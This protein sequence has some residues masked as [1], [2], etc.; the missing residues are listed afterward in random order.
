[1]S[2]NIPV[3]TMNKVHLL[4]NWGAHNSQKNKV[5]A[6]EGKSHTHIKIHINSNE[7]ISK[8][9]PNCITPKTSTFMD[10]AEHKR[11]C[12]GLW[13]SSFQGKSV[14]SSKWGTVLGKWITIKLCSSSIVCL[15]IYC[16]PEVGIEKFQKKKGKPGMQSC[17]LTITL[18]SLEICHGKVKF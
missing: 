16:T 15:L 5:L 4:A 14:F 18:N 6:F 11:T 8:K 3:L 7:R 10:S 13:Q 1:M 17:P 2:F 9:S 12:L